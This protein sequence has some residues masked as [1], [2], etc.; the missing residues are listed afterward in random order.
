MSAFNYAAI[1]L[2]LPSFLPTV[3]D[4]ADRGVDQLNK[5]RLYFS[6]SE[7]VDLKYV[8]VNSH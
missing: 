7:V 5:P 8:R 1:C 4:L 6:S 3:L 2:S